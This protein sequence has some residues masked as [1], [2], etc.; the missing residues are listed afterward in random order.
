M[1]TVDAAISPAAPELAGLSEAEAKRRL[2]ERGPLPE[3]PASR[4]YVSI[5]RANVLTRPNA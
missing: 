2:R 3:A 4:S 5:V 1:A